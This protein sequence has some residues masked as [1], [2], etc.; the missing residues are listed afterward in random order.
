MDFVLDNL[1]TCSKDKR[2]GNTQ[3]KVKKKQALESVRNVRPE[4][5]SQP[6]REGGKYE[7]RVATTPPRRT[8][9]LLFRSSSGWPSRGWG[10]IVR[11]DVCG[12]DPL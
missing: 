5:F 3:S 10:R 2:Q 12:L 9:G 6:F 4:R 11:V 7:F 8:L 1:D